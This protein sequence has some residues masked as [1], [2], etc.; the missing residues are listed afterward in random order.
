MKKYGKCLICNYI[1]E[2]KFILG[3]S[4]TWKIVKSLSYD[5]F[6]VVYMIV[7]RKDVDNIIL[8]L[9][10]DHLGKEWMNILVMQTFSCQ[11]MTIFAKIHNFSI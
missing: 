11:H 8:E 10:K 6:Y 4:I 1:K 7:K 2:G 9:P 5:S 3:Q